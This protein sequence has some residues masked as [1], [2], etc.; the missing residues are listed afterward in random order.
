[1]AYYDRDI[2]FLTVFYSKMALR[3]NTKTDFQLETFQRERHQRE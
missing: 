2:A 3:N 1:M